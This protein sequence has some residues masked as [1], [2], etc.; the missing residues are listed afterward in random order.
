MSAAPKINQPT[1]EVRRKTVFAF[2]PPEDMPKLVTR[3]IENTEARLPA[4]EQSIPKPS[5]STKPLGRR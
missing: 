4:L 3:V 2:E 5:A 1:I